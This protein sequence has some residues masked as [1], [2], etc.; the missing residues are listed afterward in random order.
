[1]GDYAMTAP[2]ETFIST[3]YDRHPT[4]LA[5]LRGARLVTAS[6]AEK[7]RQWNESR[8]KLV[9]GGDRVSARFMH[10]DFFEYTPQFKLLTMCNYRPSFRGVDE[11]IRRRLYGVPFGVTIPAHEIDKSLPEKLREEWPGILDW[12]IAGCLEW[13]REGLVP[14]RAVRD[15]TES[16]LNDEDTFGRWLDA[17]CTRMAVGWTAGADLY[18]SWKQF[19]KDEGEEPG[20]QKRFAELMQARGFVPKRTSESRGFSGLILKR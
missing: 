17:S 3:N 11:A 6:E 13:Q 18:A 8:I 19:A 12:M 7:D 10:R 9:T 2:I 5:S 14:P 4:E 15:A 20:S 16:Y 1:M